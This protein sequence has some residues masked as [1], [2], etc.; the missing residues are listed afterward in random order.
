MFSLYDNN[1]LSVKQYGDNIVKVSM[2]SSCRVGGYEDDIQYSA[3]GSVNDCKLSNNLSRA[4]TR[5]K[6]L[7]LCNSWKYWCT[8]TISPD[9]YDR[10]NLEVYRKDF[11]KF[12]KNLNLRRIEKIVYLL[13]PE[14]HE[15][16]AWHMHGFIN[17]LGDSDL[18]LNNNGYYTWKKYN[19]KF[20]YMSLSL[21]DDL[22]KSSSYCLKYMTKDKSRNVSDLGAHLYYCSK[23]LNSA[24]TLYKGHGNFHGEWDWEHPDGYVRIKNLDLR[25]DD[26]SEYVEVL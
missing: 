21:I 6:E 24:V 23:G 26:L 15:D 20:G 14:M 12:I 22:E 16:G 19:D 3:K 8:F 9:K 7:A 5:V 11:A 13:I 10:Y 25:K 18:V 2:L 17:G 1:I 4:K